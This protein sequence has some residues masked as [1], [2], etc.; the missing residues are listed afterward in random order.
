MLKC[1][2]ITVKEPVGGKY[3]LQESFTLVHRSRFQSVQ[4]VAGM[5]FSIEVCDFVS[6]A[7]SVLFSMDH[8]CYILNYEHAWTSYLVQDLRNLCAHI[9]HTTECSNTSQI[10][11][12][13]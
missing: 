2:D 12:L 8:H 10:S 1:I 6:C 9:A 4:S 7:P 11:D 13:S 5:Q 3:I